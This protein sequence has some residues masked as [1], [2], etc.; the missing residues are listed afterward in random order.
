MSFLGE[1]YP[2]DWSQVPSG[3]CTPVPDGGGYPSPG[4][5]EGVPEYPPTPEDRLCLDWLCRR[6]YASC[7]FPP[8]LFYEGGAV[9]Y[10]L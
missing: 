9:V 2:S 4:W 5:E 10:F 8:Y 6:R 7:D 3:G 1:G